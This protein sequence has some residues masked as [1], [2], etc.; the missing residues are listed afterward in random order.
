MAELYAFSRSY[1]AITEVVP[2]L[3]VTVYFI[4]VM[5]LSSLIIWV[6][7]LEIHNGHTP[8]RTY[9]D[10]FLYFWVVHFVLYFTTRFWY[11]CGVLIR[12][13]HFEF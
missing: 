9:S 11:L 13:L 7:I 3:H 8:R 10:L 4:T 6:S 5:C 12:L 2:H 1:E